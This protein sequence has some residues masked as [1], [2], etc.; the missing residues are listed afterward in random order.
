MSVISSLSSFFLLTLIFL[1][2]VLSASP[3]RDCQRFAFSDDRYGDFSPSAK[4][5]T[6]ESLRAHLAKKL[7][8]IE[9]V[10]V[11]MRALKKASFSKHLNSIELSLFQD[12]L[13]EKSYFLGSPYFDHFCLYDDIPT[14]ES[15]E[16]FVKK[17]KAFVKE[18][19]F[20][21]AKKNHL[22]T[23][24]QRIAILYTGG[25]GGGH[26]S[27]AC[28]LKQ[29]L[30]KQGY[31]I[32]FIDIDEVENKYSPR[33][34][35]LKKAEIYSEIFQKE[36]DVEKAKKLWKLIDQKQTPEMRRSVGDIRSSIKN[37][38]ADHI[39]CVAHHRPGISYLSYSLGIPMTY[40]H[41]D[42]IFNK[43]LLPVLKEQERQPFVL[44]QF[45][46]LTA[47]KE[48]F[49]T[50]FESF[51]IKGKT[52]P[53]SIKEQLVRLDFPVRESF[54]K[55]TTFEEKALREEFAIDPEAIVCK[56]AMGQ[57]GASDEIRGILKKLVREL[58]SQ[59]QALHVFVICGKNEKLKESLSR[60]FLKKSAA[61][62]GLVLHLC[63]FMEEQEMAK[64]DK[65]SDV[66]ITKPGGATCAELVKTQKQMLYILTAHHSWEE[67]NA[68]FLKKLHLGDELLLS[69]S[70]VK[71]IEQRVEVAKH[72]KK[73]SQKNSD[74]R[75]HVLQI[76]Q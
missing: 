62:T 53:H 13:C 26:K 75:E 25:F 74:W 36:G 72:L 21:D 41:T 64:V 56:L 32:L 61:K 46:A 35:G 29:F 37:F 69:K 48:F 34:L 67:T 18:I 33:V 31:D 17:Y 42:H 6:D 5:K 23:H 4:V 7:N 2:H 8:D 28:A 51:K 38:D 43:S 14:L 63:G 11:V 9:R 65:I 60:L 47:D 44:I 50:I 22:S 39:F 15:D 30:S 66:W 71:Q 76:V 68:A 20:Q 73:M 58:R 54:T 12:W 40:V 45:G 16:K 59:K 19:A 10:D 52:L 3:D 57:N 55:P 27:P 1:Q 24:K 49:K 70:L